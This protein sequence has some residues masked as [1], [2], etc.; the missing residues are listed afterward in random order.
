MTM[1]VLLQLFLGHFSLV[2][3]SCSSDQE[4]TWDHKSYWA[5]NLHH[6]SWEG[7][8]NQHQ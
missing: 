4:S 6:A 1:T 5:E 3:N 8:A 2:N 7:E